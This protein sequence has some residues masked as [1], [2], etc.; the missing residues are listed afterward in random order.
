MILEITENEDDGD[1]DENVMKVINFIIRKKNLLV[2]MK[3]CHPFF[4][5]R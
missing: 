1:V 4:H 5:F 3:I 2:L